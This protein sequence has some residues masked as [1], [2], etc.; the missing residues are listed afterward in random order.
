MPTAYVTVQQLIDAFSEREIIELTDRAT[1]RANAVDTA[2]AQRACDRARVEVDAALA[3][4]YA[5]PL[6]TVPE[7]LHYLALDLAR[8]YLHEHEPPPLVQT[9]FDAARASL[10][11]LAAGRASLGLD[12][13]GLA[14]KP[15]PSDLPAFNSGAKDF[16]RGNW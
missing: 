8:F 14:V 5:L 11:D 7:L 10:R 13:A 3:V 9:R 1:P 4:R 6:A 12:D 16:A 2:V 15:A